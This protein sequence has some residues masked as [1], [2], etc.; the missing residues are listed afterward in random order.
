MTHLPY[1]NEN[2][3]ESLNFRLDDLQLETV[4][5]NLTIDHFNNTNDAT[6]LNYSV[7]LYEHLRYYHQ[8]LPSVN[9]SINN[10]I[11]LF[12]LY[13]KYSSLYFNMDNITSSFDFIKYVCTQLQGSRLRRHSSSG[14][15]R[16][17]VAAT[18]G[19]LLFQLDKIC[20]DIQS[21]TPENAI[22]STIISSAHSKINELIESVGSNDKIISPPVILHKIEL[23]KDQR[24]KLQAIGNAI[25]QDYELRRNMLMTR[26]D[27]TIQSFLWGEAA[28]GKEGEIVAAIKAQRDNLT[29]ESIKYST[30]DALMAPVT[31]LYEHSKRVTDSVGSKSLVKT[32]I[33]GH[34][35]DRGG[36]TNEMRPKSRDI[37]PAWARKGAGRGS[38]GHHHGGRGGG[39]HHGK[40]KSGGGENNK[41]K[42]GS[43][44]GGKGKNSN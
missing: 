38:G 43:G 10:I 26:R 6:V 5:G 24:V 11:D 29:E 30:E 41:G 14:Q 31:L 3:L 33:I 4:S 18:R 37:Q 16:R 2:E 27:V 1:Y 36:R 9:E 39:K 44:K 7:K 22:E 17:K 40:G 20:K 32:V 15:T 8:K 35:P 19:Q 12:N 21:K 13:E 34:V 23:S 42:G 28:Q 25:T